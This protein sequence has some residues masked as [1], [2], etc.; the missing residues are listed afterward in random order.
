MVQRPHR[1]HGLDNVEPRLGGEHHARPAT[2]GC[3]VDAAAGILGAGTKVVDLYR[4]GPGAPGLADEAC[5]EPV[6]H[7][8]GE[9][10]EDLDLHSSKRPSGAS[11]TTSPGSALTTKRNGTRAP[12]SS[13]NKSLAGFASTASTLPCG[14]PV[15]PTTSEPISSCTHSPSCERTASA[16]NKA[17]ASASALARSATPTKL[18]SQ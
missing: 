14:T 11:T 2:E 12:V 15:A 8:V 4:Q 3:V 7:H 13:T 9:D 16:S 17:P 18:A 5:P 6:G 10:C 1:L